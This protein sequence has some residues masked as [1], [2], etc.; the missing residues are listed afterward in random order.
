MSACCVI[1]SDDVAENP[2]TWLLVRSCAE[3]HGQWQVLRPRSRRATVGP[4][5]RGMTSGGDDDA[6]TAH[7]VP[8]GAL[9][10]ILLMAHVLCAVVGFGTMVATGAQAARARRGPAAAGSDGVRRYFRPGVN[11]AGRVLYGVPVFGFFLLGAS[12]GAFSAGDGFVVVGLVLWFVAAGLAEAVVWP[13]ERR[14]QVG[15]TQR[16]DETGT[17]PA[18]E[19]ECRRVAG[20][21][22]VLAVVFVAATVIMIGKP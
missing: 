3:R 11:W 14:I 5:W 8:T 20:S 19:R 21:A 9:Y 16:W 12:Q 22:A 15:V 7:G 13:G 10:T 1:G 4:S 6:V 18:L 17:D 2:F